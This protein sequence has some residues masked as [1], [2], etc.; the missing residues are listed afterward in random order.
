MEQHGC[1]K[2]DKKS[3]IDWAI[4][5]VLSHRETLKEIT[6][7]LA[8]S[9][10]VRFNLL[11]ERNDNVFVISVS[12][13]STIESQGGRDDGRELNLSIINDSETITFLPQSVNASWTWHVRFRERTSPPANNEKHKIIGINQQN[14]NKKWK[15]QNLMTTRNVFPFKFA[16]FVRRWMRAVWTEVNID[17]QI[18]YL[19]VIIRF[20]SQ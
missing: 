6:H 13:I 3:V 10:P 16:F 9:Q 4:L 7:T 20:F 12:T 17:E 5:W 15:K 8:P 18:K 19:T 2:R 11:L 14:N 1:R